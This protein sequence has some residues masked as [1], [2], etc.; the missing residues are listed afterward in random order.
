MIFGERALAW[1]KVSGGDRQRSHMP[2]SRYS[3]LQNDTGTE[4]LWQKGWS[5]GQMGWPA[6]NLRL[7]LQPLV[8]VRPA[9]FR[10]QHGKQEE[11][12]PLLQDSVSRCQAHCSRA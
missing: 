2:V 10:H 8:R 5:A 9:D 6:L 7:S 3:S 11:T 12:S 4:N 1:Q